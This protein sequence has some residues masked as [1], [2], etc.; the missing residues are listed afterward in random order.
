MHCLNIQNHIQVYEPSDMDNV[1]PFSDATDNNSCEHGGTGNNSIKNNSHGH[2]STVNT[3]IKKNN[4]VFRYQHR[5]H[6]HLQQ[7]NNKS[8][9]SV[10]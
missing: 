2:D 6:H 9:N 10:Y 1:K 3:P 5:R 4:G 8:V 7:G